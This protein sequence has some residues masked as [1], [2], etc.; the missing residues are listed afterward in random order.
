MDYK[1]FSKVELAGI[2]DVI[3][4]AV[5][6]NAESD[7]HVLLDKVKDM[8]CG[9][10]SV[11]GIGKGGGEGVTEPPL[12]INGNYSEEWL[13]TYGGSRLYL[14]DPI[15]WHNFQHP[16]AQLW[17]ETY[18]MYAEQVSR[19]FVS[20]SQDFGLYYGVSGGIFDPRSGIA[21]IFTF[22]GKGN[23]FSGHQKDIMSI[24]SPHLHQALLRAAKET[25]PRL[26]SSLSSREKEVIS[27]IKEGKTNWEISV[28]LGISERTV[29]FHVQNIERKL[30]AV[31]KTHAI[32]IALEQNLV[33]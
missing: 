14:K 16:G 9:D 1:K 5:Q 17:E 22:S 24:V 23:T 21:T 11:C 20:R 4:L 3:Q 33:S 15:I 12:V 13:R 8:V 19:D 25:Q 6:S 31:N 32:A 27:W 18:D 10:Y 28:I 29:K 7:I 2:L 30:N 26:F